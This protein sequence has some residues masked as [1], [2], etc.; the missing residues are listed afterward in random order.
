MK[1]I[2]VEKPQKLK[3]VL[4]GNSMSGFKFCEKYLKYGVYKRYELA[5]DLIDASVDSGNCIVRYPLRPGFES[6][7]IDGKRV[8]PLMGEHKDYDNG[9]LG[10]LNYPNL[11]MDCISDYTWT[12]RITPID[13]MRTTVDLTWLVGGKAVEGI[14]YE[15][16]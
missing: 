16:D 1:K 11:F 15:T 2:S 12:M 8:A 9:V 7:S 4:I 3:L 13:A 5:V 10:L 14:D 6:Y